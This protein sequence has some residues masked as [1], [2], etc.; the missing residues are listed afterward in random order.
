MF[1]STDREYCFSVTI[2]D[3]MRYEANEVFTVV[4]SGLFDE[5]PLSVTNDTVRIT[6]EDADRTFSVSCRGYNYCDYD[7][8][9]L[10]G[11][12]WSLHRWPT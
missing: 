9:S 4:A 7:S 2:S 3:D 12:T 10:L 1:S 11:M 6:V 8:D 5:N